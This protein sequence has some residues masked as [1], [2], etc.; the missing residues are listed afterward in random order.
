MSDMSLV[1]FLQPVFSLGRKAWKYLSRLYME[2]QTG[3]RMFQDDE[4]GLI[5]IELD[6]TL[7]RLRGE[8]VED[9]FLSQIKTLIEHPL[10]TPKFLRE[11]EIKD[12][13][14]DHQVRSDLKVLASARLM[15]ASEDAN[16]VVERLREAHVNI[17]KK[18]IPFADE[19][20]DV[21]VNILTAGYK[22]GIHGIWSHCLA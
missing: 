17:S 10:V 16:E 18:E 19:A 21:V 7:A 12:W 5:D 8:E 1:S 20:I 9:T 2:R 22:A 3:R 11:A 6:K 15:G 4:S 13:L 14:S